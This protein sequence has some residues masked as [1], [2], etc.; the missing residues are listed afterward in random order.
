MQADREHS[1]ARSIETTGLAQ[2]LRFRAECG[3]VER[4]LKEDCWIHPEL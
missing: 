2:H 4:R 3:T 1:W